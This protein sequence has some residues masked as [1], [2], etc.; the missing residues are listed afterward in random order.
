MVYYLAFQITIPLFVSLCLC[1]GAVVGKSSSSSPVTGNVNPAACCIVMYQL[2]QSRISNSDQPL[3]PFHQ[4]CTE[5]YIYYCIK[6]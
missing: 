6:K 2:D 1:K 5:K 4:Q 3:Q